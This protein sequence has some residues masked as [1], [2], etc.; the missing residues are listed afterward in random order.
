MSGAHR[1]AVGEIKEN[2]RG[3]EYLKEVGVEMNDPKIA[4]NWIKYNINN[5]PTYVF[6]LNNNYLA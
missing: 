3:E 2:L 1:L 5:T 4:E 6:K